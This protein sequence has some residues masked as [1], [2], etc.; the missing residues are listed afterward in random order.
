MN[1]RDLA[2][3]PLSERAYLTGMGASW[4]TL[5]FLAVPV[6][7]YVAPIVAACIAF[8][9]MGRRLRTMAHQSWIAYVPAFAYLMIGLTWHLVGKVEGRFE[10]LPGVL[11]VVAAVIGFWP[12]SWLFE[13]GRKLAKTANADAV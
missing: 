9:V 1:I 5:I 3:A 10:D 7:E 6:L 13:R 12:T 11:C 8:F 2:T 4:A